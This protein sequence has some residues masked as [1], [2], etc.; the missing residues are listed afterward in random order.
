M[1]VSTETQEKF[2]Q[3]VAK[4]FGLDLKSAEAA[5]L[6]NDLVKYYRLLHQLDQKIKQANEG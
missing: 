4:E 5:A 6:L 3:V 2:K 1:A